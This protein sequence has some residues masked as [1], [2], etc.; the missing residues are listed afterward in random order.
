MTWLGRA[1]PNIRVD[2]RGLDRGR[3]YAPS[4]EGAGWPPSASTRPAPGPAPS[5]RWPA[6]SAEKVPERP[7]P[8]A[9]KGSTTTRRPARAPIARPGHGEGRRFQP[10]GPCSASRN[11]LTSL[12][13][14]RSPQDRR[15]R[16]IPAAQVSIASSRT[17]STAEL[18][19]RSQRVPPCHLA[20]QHDPLT[21]HGRKQP[22]RANRL[23]EA[24]L[25]A[26]SATSSI[27]GV[28]FRLR[29]CTRD[30]GSGRLPVQAPRPG[31]EPFH[32][33]ISPVALGP[34]SRSTRAPCYPVPCSPSASR[35]TCRRSGR[36]ARP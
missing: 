24:A 15:A 7:R 2:A 35:R 25:H 22:A 26:G 28:D 20:A 33:H 8:R 13:P 10:A 29:R 17:W 14:C 18:R 6:A 9:G 23:A 30:R 36:R 1:S 4:R 11:P 27:G 16:T 5:R 3:P 19:R 31:R 32:R 34:H 12:P 21:G